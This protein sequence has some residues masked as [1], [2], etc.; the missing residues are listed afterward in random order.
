MSLSKR[1][2][3][4]HK[5]PIDFNPDSLARALEEA[6]PEALFAFLFGSSINGHVSVGSDL[7]LAL[8]IN[9]RM[10]LDLLDRVQSAVVERFLPG[11]HCDIGSLRNAEPI[12]R[13]EALKGRLLFTRD[14]EVYLRFFSLTCREYES[15][16]HDYARQHRYRMANH[17]SRA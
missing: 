13:F 17:D 4:R 12:Y 7:D 9:G 16:I 10:S 3:S 6:C 5:K 14:S 1:H 11:V 15:Q 2:L 8:F